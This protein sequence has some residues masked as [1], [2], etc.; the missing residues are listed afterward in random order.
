MPWFKKYVESGRLSMIYR[1]LLVVWDAACINLC[2]FAALFI[3]YELRWDR[4]LKS[5]ITSDYPQGY[6]TTLQELIIINTLITL[7]IFA[8][9]RLYNSLWRYASLGEVLNIAVACLL[10]AVVHFLTVFGTYR[11]LPRSYFVIYLLL[12]FIMTLGVRFSYRIIRLLYNENVHG[13]GMRNTMVIGAGESGNIVINELKMSKKLDSNICCI[14]DDNK[15]K[16]NTFINGVKVIGGRDQILDAAKYFAINEIVLAM[17]SA[18]KKDV[19][20]ILELCQQTGAELKILPGVYQFVNGEA[21]VEKLRPVQIEDLL[22]REPVKTNLESITGYVKNKVVLVT[23]GGGSIGS[24]LCRQLAA[25]QPKM[26]IIFDVY[27]NNAYDIQ[28]ELRA[29]YPHMHLEVLIGSVRNT[30]RVDKIFEQYRPDIVYHAAAHKHVPLMEDSPNEAIKNNVF[31]TYKTALAADKYGAKKFVLIS[32]D[33]AV[34]PTNI[35]GASKRICE[36]IVQGLNR[37]SSTDFVAVRFGNVL[38]SNGSVIPLF[39]KQ[40]EAGGPVTVTDKNIIR[41]FMTIPEAVSLVLQAGAFARGGE[42][43]VL[44]MGEP[45]KID[46]L[47]RNLIKLSGYVP[48]EDIKIVYTGLR[49]GEKLYEEILMDEEGL[50]ETENALIH[51]GK[52]IEFDEAA[53]FD[54]LERLY[55]EVYNE[56]PNIKEIISDL[57]PTYHIKEEERRREKKSLDHKFTA[58]YESSKKLPH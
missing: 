5:G 15:S 34:N 10:S 26:L 54:Q 37:Q 47:A 14:I 7:L 51:I 29:K 21:A 31:G 53:F 22:G 20:E 32:T 57:V 46:D 4:F 30:S 9:F 52:P 33:K 43:F 48:D 6:V 55:E 11:R 56:V 13:V 28:Q 39:K 8:L 2:S 27:E 3:R 50:T 25:N 1:I 45:V 38:G 24:E 36:M 40:I 12:L 16:H 17:P 23:G 41:Y 49:P 35:M 42:I 19:K 58:F 44:D 18:P